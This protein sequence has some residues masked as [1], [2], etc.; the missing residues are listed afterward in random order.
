[1]EGQPGQDIPI[2]EI[3]LKAYE[4]P[5]SS[6][7]VEV[8]AGILG[9]HQSGGG[10]VYFGLLVRR[11]QDAPASIEFLTNTPSSRTRQPSRGS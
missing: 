1:M 9:G 2:D 8:S 10:N 6:H 4:W 3:W 7:I 5:P 11:S